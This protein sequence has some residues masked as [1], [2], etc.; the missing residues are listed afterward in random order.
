MRAFV[1][2]AAALVALLTASASVDARSTPRYRVALRATVYQSLS[3]TRREQR[4]DC[5]TEQTGLGRRTVDVRTARP[6]TLTGATPTIRASASVVEVLPPA[7]FET[8]C[9]DEVKGFGHADCRGF[10]DRNHPVNVA[11]R[12]SGR[13][14]TLAADE[15]DRAPHACALREGTLDVPVIRLSAAS[16]RLPRD[17][18][19]ARRFVVRASHRETR[20]LEQGGVTAR[21]EVEIRWVLTFRRTSS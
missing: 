6:V 16:G 4:G 14:I 12:R 19:T 3:Y 5:T 21:L 2:T 13:T 9:G 20:E 18:F 11:A 10:E 15:L 8:R 1:V 7:G 17:A